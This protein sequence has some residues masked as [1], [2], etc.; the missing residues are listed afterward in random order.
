MS[1]GQPTGGE[2]APVA[3]SSTPR[4]AS[5]GS[6]TPTP[7][8]ASF[9]TPGPVPEGVDPFDHRVFACL[10]RAALADAPRPLA[11]ALGLD[12]AALA[13]LGARYFP[14]APLD[15][16]APDAGPDALEEPDLRALLRAHRT[17]G[18]EEEAWLAAIVARRALKPDHL[19][20]DLGLDQR[21]DLTRFLERHFE[22]LATRNVHNM[23]WKKFFYR[24]LCEAE[25]VVVCKSPTCAE[26][27]DYA[28]CFGPETGGGS[29]A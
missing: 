17:R 18:I 28:D 22:S 11:H 8:P 7:A 10:V 13:R 15:P 2:R 14:D 9:W 16:G 6:S 20:Q 21:A 23:R 12:P 26:C 19:W 1:P 3:G 29:R 4:P 5:A 27:V 25:G 24:T